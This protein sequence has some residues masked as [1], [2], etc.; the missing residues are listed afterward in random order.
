MSIY[1]RTDPPD[2]YFID[3][4]TEKTIKLNKYIIL[5]I[6]SFLNIDSLS[7][8]SIINKKFRELFSDNEF[9]K[10]F[11]QRLAKNFPIFMKSITRRHLPIDSLSLHVNYLINACA[12]H[13]RPW[14]LLC[15]V[16]SNPNCNFSFPISNAPLVQQSLI[17]G[18]ESVKSELEHQMKE[19]CGN[20]YQDPNSKIHQAWLLRKNT[21]LKFKELTSFSYSNP[22]LYLHINHYTSLMENSYSKN[23]DI[24]SHKEIYNA[25]NNFIKL[26]KENRE[27]KNYDMH[28]W[29]D[30]ILQLK[31]MNHQ[32]NEYLELEHLRSK[33]EKFLEIANTSIKNTPNHIETFSNIHKLRLSN[34][35]NFIILSEF[36]HLCQNSLSL[37][38]KFDTKAIESIKN[39]INML[40]KE[41]KTLIC[42]KFYSEYAFYAE[43]ESWVENHFHEFPVEFTQEILNQKEQLMGELENPN[44]IRF[45]VIL[46]NKN[47]P[48][49]E[50]IRML[51]NSSSASQLIWETLYK[52]CSG[53][54]IEERWAENHFHEFLPT[55][56]QILTN[57][58]EEALEQSLKLAQ[59]LKLLLPIVL[60]TLLTEKKLQN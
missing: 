26:K 1:Q 14:K 45:R 58:H 4:E 42:N 39:Y 46:E 20:G 19:I 60:D 40:P 27:L 59:E 33:T 5:H 24:Y 36:F 53:K 34:I 56:H 50:K 10:I 25:H 51:I 28:D 23:S 38:S 2:F 12:H 52:S 32:M 9:K 35:K 22:Q 55:L 8:L 3:A 15:S 37:Q 11:E 48:P 30:I 18:W 41:I 31:K 49:L 21:Q 47:L 7:N 6:S 16:F 44:L 17:Q 57:L 54:T 43:E 13:D 29:V